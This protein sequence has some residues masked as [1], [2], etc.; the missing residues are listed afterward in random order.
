M[1]LSKFSNDEI[2][3]CEQELCFTAKGKQAKI[4]GTVVTVALALFTL[5]KL[6]KS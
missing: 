6:I 4:I 3:I 2:S 1:Y 5:S